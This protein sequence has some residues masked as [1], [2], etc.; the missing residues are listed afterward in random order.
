VVDDV[1]VAAERPVGAGHL[2]GGDDGVQLGAVSDGAAADAAVAGAAAEAHDVPSGL[3]LRQK[4]TW[5]CDTKSDS[6]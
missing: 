6:L 4:V 5:P 3:A 1:P 2:G